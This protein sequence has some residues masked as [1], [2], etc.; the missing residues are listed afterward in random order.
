MGTCTSTIT[1]EHPAHQPIV[2]KLSADVS[3]KVSNLIELLQPFCD[4]GIAFP[5]EHWKSP[6]ISTTTHQLLHNVIDLCNNLVRL[7]TLSEPLCVILMQIIGLLRGIDDSLR[8]QRVWIVNAQT[9]NHKLN[10]L[11]LMNLTS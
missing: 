6:Y 7:L 8:K 10:D 3:K 5:A 11:K 2:Q 4:E 1:T 9:L